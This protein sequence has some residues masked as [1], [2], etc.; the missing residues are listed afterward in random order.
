M[1]S[2]IELWK[3]IKHLSKKI[4]LNYPGGDSFICRLFLW[5]TGARRQTRQDVIV[6]SI[7]L[8]GKTPADFKEKNPVWRFLKILS[9]QLFPFF[10]TTTSKRVN[11]DFLGSSDE[12]PDR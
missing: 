5:L 8:P 9:E 6:L 1:S 4:S 11:I 10:F 7:V 12:K 3:S 2:I